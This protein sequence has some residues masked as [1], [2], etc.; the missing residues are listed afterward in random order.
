MAT[1]PPHLRNSSGSSFSQRL[2]YFLAGT[3]I[4]LV[5]LGLLVSSRQRAAQQQAAERDAEQRRAEVEA[6]DGA[7]DGESGHETD[8][9]GP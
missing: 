8:S 6:R 1:T 4:G 2:G 5:A 9:D 7:A 3:A